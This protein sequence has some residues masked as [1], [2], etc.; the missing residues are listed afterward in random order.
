MPQVTSTS[1]INEI[2][3]FHCVVVRPITSSERFDWDTLMSRHHY[4]G[5]R[6]LVGE[7]IRYVAEIKGS[8]VALLGWSAAALKCQPRDTWI[9]CPQVIQW[10]R[11]RL[12]SRPGTKYWWI[13][14]ETP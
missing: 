13:S 1:Q 4:L 3:L 12:P 10:Q 14:S 6:S 7:S 11:L 5:F 9:G 8:W 2:P